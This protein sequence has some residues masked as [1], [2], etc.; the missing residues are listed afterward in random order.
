MVKT[1]ILINYAFWLIGLA[2]IWTQI[3]WPAFK[4]R[5]LCPIWRSAPREAEKALAEALQQSDIR[6]TREAARTV[7]QAKQKQ[8]G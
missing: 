8:E 7:K 4:G 6:T 1:V 5:P 2:L 3:V